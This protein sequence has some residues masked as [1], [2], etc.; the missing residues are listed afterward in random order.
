MKIIRRDYFRQYSHRDTYIHDFDN[1][2]H[3]LIITI[4]KLIQ[5]NPKGRAPRAEHVGECM[6]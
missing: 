2:I 4:G 3:K 6:R 1:N 5:R